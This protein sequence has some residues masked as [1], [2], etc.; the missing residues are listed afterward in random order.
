MENKTRTVHIK[1][2]TPVN[3][4]PWLH[5]LP[6]LLPTE[7]RGKKL[8][9]TKGKFGF[10]IHL[11]TLKLIFEEKKVMCWCTSE[12]VIKRLSFVRGFQ[13]D[14]SWPW[15]YMI[16]LNYGTWKLTCTED[17]MSGCFTWWKTESLQLLFQKKKFRASRNF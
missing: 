11:C 7:Q 2:K 6:L 14:K 17:F 8:D 4:L 10:F 9:R 16:G 12:Y 13:V 5:F 1:K 15:K 3:L